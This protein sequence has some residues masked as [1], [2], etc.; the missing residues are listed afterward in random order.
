MLDVGGNIFNGSPNPNW[1]GITAPTAQISANSNS[2]AGLQMTNAGTGT[3]TDFR[4][5]VFAASSTS[6]S[7]QDYMA[8]AVPA[9]SNTGTLFGQNRSAIV[10]V[11][12]NAQGLAT[13]ASWR[14]ARSTIMP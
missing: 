9:F 7:A 14:L 3:A 8:F 13:D 5:A 12:A 4:F 10:T 1:G 11:F 6:A 2:I